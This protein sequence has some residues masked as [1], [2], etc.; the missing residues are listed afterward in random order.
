MLARRG[1]ACSIMRESLHHANENA[2]DGQ[3]AQA[4]TAQIKQWVPD[5]VLTENRA[6]DFYVRYFSA[7]MSAYREHRR[8]EKDHKKFEGQY[9]KRDAR[10]AETVSGTPEMPERISGILQRMERTQ[11]KYVR[12]D[13]RME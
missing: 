1:T 11:R 10:G 4:L 3:E 6:V 13:R 12:D 8:L 7:F 9:M 5:A 2:P